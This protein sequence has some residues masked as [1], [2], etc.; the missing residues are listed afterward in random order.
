MPSNWWETRW[1]QLIA[2][3]PTSIIDATIAG[4]QSDLTCTEF[5]ISVHSGFAQTLP[6]W[7]LGR[8]VF[9]VDTPASG[10]FSYPQLHT[11]ARTPSWLVFIRTYVRVFLWVTWSML[12]YY[13]R[14]FELFE[15]LWALTRRE[16][17]LTHQS[18]SHHQSS[19]F[20]CSYFDDLAR[21]HSFNLQHSNW[22]P[23]EVRLV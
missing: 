22:S 8:Q 13:W 19:P 14:P 21:F 16:T 5:L 10:K 20:F 23:L 15:V 9:L 3:S 2:R 18:S 1:L 17:L 4:V 12:R 11:L 7:S 6:C